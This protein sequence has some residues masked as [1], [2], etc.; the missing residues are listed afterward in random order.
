[1]CEA[2]PDVV[3]LLQK[4]KPQI[5]YSKTE[6]HVYLCVVKNVEFYIIKI[7]AGKCAAA[8]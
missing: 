8:N 1:M 3:V 7:A 4:A 6:Y 5:M 2:G